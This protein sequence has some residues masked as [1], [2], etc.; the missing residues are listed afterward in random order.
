MPE[1]R[2]PRVRYAMKDIH[3]L[4]PAEGKLGVLLPGLGAV[5][6]TTIAGIL[7]ARRGLGRPIGS[8]TQ[9]GTLRLGAQG[10][11]RI[12][13][14]ADTVPL[15]NLGQLEFG[16]WDIFPDNAWEAALRA[17]V[18]DRSHLHEI[19]E[20][21]EAIRP[22]KGVFSPGYVKRLSGTHTKCARSKAEMVELVRED[23]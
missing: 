11:E 20:E 7:L 5:A 14:V 10:L 21:L 1:P 22:M 2:A 15:A 3:S 16:A 9:M 12:A 6:T 18:L 4:R 19:R 17:Q 23:V 13:R 8:I